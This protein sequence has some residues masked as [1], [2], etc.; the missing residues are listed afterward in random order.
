MLSLAFMCSRRLVSDHRSMCSA[1]PLIPEELYPLLFRAAFLDKK[2]LVL[3]DLVH[4]WPFSVL[5]LQRLL[6]GDGHHRSVQ[7]FEKANRLCVQTIIL[8]IMAYLKEELARQKQ[9]QPLRKKRLRLLDM[10]GIHEDGLE[11]GPD[12]M[13]LWFRTVT[14]AKS[15]IDIAKRQS[16]ETGQVSK[17]RRGHLYA[18]RSSVADSSTICVELRADLFVNSTSYAVL[19][20]ALLV[21]NQGPLRLQCR[22]IRAEELSL[23]STMGL[24]ELL[25]PASLRQ[26]DLRFNNLGLPGLN[27]LL[28]YMKRFSRLQSLKL[29]YSNIDV[30]RLS[31]V[32]EEDLQNFVSQICQLSA[33]K[34]LNLGSSR[35]SGRLQQLLRG[36]RTPLESLELAFCYLLPADL[37]YLSQSSH[38]SSLKKLDLSGNNLCDVLLQPFLQLLD[39]ASTSL[40]HLDVME[41]KLTDSALSALT[42][43]LR[44]CRSL[45]YLGIF[46][47]FLSGQGIRSLLQSSL[48]LADL[49]LVIYPFPMECYLNPTMQPDFSNPALDGCIDHGQVAGFQAE[50]QEVLVRAQR[51]DMVWTADMVL[52]RPPEYLSL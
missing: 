12:T 7:L 16:E 44:R 51:T 28:P 48:H 18:A 3:Q 40:L 13:S 4:R 23:G 10:T 37:Y 8:G 32:G 20:E 36:L 38:V 17:R 26:I 22:D 5:S 6:Q 39:C 1:L 11:Q 30:R 35:L 24:L 49:Q 9:G 43:V 31:Q 25:N 52:H 15:C 29:P 2:T 45:R 42:P 19:R 14:L 34:E 27:A 33:L 21:G 47:N 50:L 41:C 46:Y